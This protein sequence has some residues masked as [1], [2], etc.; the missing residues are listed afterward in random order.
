MNISFPI[1]PNVVFQALQD[2]GKLGLALDGDWLSSRLS[3]ED[4]EIRIYFTDS[5]ADP[6][7]RVLEHVHLEI[8]VENDE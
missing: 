6:D 3:K 8:Y 7:D 5:A 1:D 4:A 2:A